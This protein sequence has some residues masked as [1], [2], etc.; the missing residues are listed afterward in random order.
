[1]EQKDDATTNGARG[2]ATQAVTPRTPGRV[3]WASVRAA[4]VLLQRSAGPRVAGRTTEPPGREILR[5]TLYDQQP[6]MLQ[7][8][9]DTF[10]A[11]EAR[12]DSLCE[13]LRTIHGADS[14][15]QD[16]YGQSPLTAVDMAAADEGAAAPSR[17]RNRP[18]IPPGFEPRVTASIA[19]Q[20]AAQVALTGLSA[21]RR[22]ARIRQPAGKWWTHQPPQEQVHR[23]RILGTGTYRE[24]LPG[25]RPSQP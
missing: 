5:G 16:S 25:R 7:S 12:H 8:G 19:A 9:G 1:M 10:A 15:P 13:I 20:H 6:L 23:N 11:C 17:Q 4:T 21:V 2:R 14:L 22:S 24:G 18:A 3:E